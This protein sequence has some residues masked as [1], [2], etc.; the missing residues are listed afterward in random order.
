MDDSPDDPADADTV[1]ESQQAADDDAI[2]TT[3]DD[4]AAPTSPHAHCNSPPP[5]PGPDPAQDPGSPQL[6]SQ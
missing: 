3:S 5:S 1:A 6:D 4:D 2:M